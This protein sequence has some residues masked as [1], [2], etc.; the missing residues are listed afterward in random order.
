MHQ[1]HVEE[2]VAEQE[3][4]P[5][6]GLLRWR[7]ALPDHWEDRLNHNIWLGPFSQSDLHDY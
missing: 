6:V 7:I 5:V 4:E 3:V 2:L 1:G